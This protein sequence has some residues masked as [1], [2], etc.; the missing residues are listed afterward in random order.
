[1]TDQ[2]DRARLLINDALGGLDVLCKTSERLLHDSHM[3]TMLGQ[4]VVDGP[5]A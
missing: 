5:P 2:H 3:E 1:M 4:D